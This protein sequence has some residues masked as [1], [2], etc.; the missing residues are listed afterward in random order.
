MKNATGGFRAV[1]QAAGV[2]L[3]SVSRVASRRGSVN[4]EL[5]ARVLAAAREGGVELEGRRRSK[6]I[7]FLLCN[8]DLLHPIHS[9]IYVGAENYCGDQGWELVFQPYRYVAN[10]A[11]KKMRL[12]TLL[13]RRDVVR[14]VIVAGTNTAELLDCLERHGLPYSVFGNNLFGE[15]TTN[16][17]DTVFMD[18]VGGAREMTQYL[19]GLGHRRICFVGN[20]ELPWN[21][22]SVA[23]YRAAMHEAGL[24]PHVAGLHSDERQVGYLSTRALI[25]RREPVTAI[26]AS[27]DPTAE[28]VY[29]G[30]RDCG[31]R[32]PEDVSVAGINDTEGSLLTPPLTTVR[33]FP[34]EIGRHL[35]E[36]VL[37][38]VLHPERPRQELLIPTQLVKRAS[39]REL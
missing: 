10:T 18:D 32:V 4:P 33:S 21:A 37:E 15:H 2:S 35:A 34:E 8:R 3:A 16:R 38:R 27:A 17:C 22:R 23:G 19:I 29:R 30:L 25:A 28:G 12:P 26:L 1:A 14:G 9:R 24:E 6:V 36:M 7:S 5:E 13:E 39:C 20:A 11:P 31:L